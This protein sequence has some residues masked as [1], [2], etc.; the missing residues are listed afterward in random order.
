MF[1]ASCC[2]AGRFTKREGFDGHEPAVHT[3]MLVVVCKQGN[4]FIVLINTDIVSV[5]YGRRPGISA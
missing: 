2:C 1:E 4:N 3:C 5:F